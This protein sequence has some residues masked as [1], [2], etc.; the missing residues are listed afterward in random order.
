MATSKAAAAGT[1]NKE[2]AKVPTVKGPA[3]SKGKADPEL[4]P[5]A[6]EAGPPLEDDMVSSE[7]GLNLEEEEGA[8]ILAPPPGLHSPADQQQNIKDKGTYNQCCGAGPFLTGSGYFFLR[9]RLQVL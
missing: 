3:A 6:E 2:A 8:G 5:E 1:D 4:I 7:D 9:L